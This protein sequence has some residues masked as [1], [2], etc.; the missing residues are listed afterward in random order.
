MKLRFVF[1]LVLCAASV[2][3]FAQKG[4]DIIDKKEVLRIENFLASDELKGRKPGTPGIE[5]AAD[6]I[7]DEFK[8]S[9][10]SFL[11]NMT[12]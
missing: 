3:S 8:K 7:S 10:L 2:F 6:F 12:S 11:P 4:L 9:G 5:K 1:S